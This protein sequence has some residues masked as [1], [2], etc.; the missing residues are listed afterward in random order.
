MNDERSV[1]LRCS[2]F[3][4]H[5]SSLLR[6]RRR[7]WIAERLEVHLRRSAR[8]CHAAEVCLRL[9]SE[10]VRDNVGRELQHSGVELLRDFVV[11]PAVDRDA[12][13]ASLEL[14]LQLEEI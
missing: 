10:E 8:S 12:I 13:L 7:L 11:P 3:I 4:A 5:R 9:E 1:I 14:R 6:R 2:S